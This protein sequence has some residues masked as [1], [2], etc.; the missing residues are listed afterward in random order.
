[1]SI[2][3]TRQTEYFVTRPFEQGR[4]KTPQ[5]GRM[6][7]YW[8]ENPEIAKRVGELLKRGHLVAYEYDS[9]RGTLDFREHLYRDGEQVG[10]F[11]LHVPEGK[12]PFYAL[13]GAFEEGRQRFSDKEINYL[14]GLHSNFEVRKT[15]RTPVGLTG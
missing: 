4:S 6:A 7:V 5:V 14:L 3:I 13:I 8:G 15:R 11:D 10:H 9:E 12:D 1:M 2:K